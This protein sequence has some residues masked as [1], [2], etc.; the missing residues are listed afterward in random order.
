METRMVSDMTYEMD[1]QWFDIQK[2]QIGNFV[3]IYNMK[4]APNT[5]KYN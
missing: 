4:F 2:M 3:G 1:F 5:L